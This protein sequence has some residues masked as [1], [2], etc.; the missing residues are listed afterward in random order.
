MNLKRPDES[1]QRWSTLRAGFQSQSPPFESA[2]V[3]AT[4][5][6]MTQRLESVL[7]AEIPP[8]RSLDGAPSRFRMRNPGNLAAAN[9]SHSSQYQ[10][11]RTSC[12]L[13]HNS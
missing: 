7:K 8:K 5:T 12:F 2:K 1:V 9:F 6:V 10:A 3:R 4:S 11:T 13:N